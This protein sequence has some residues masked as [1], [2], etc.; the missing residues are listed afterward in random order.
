MDREL[1]SFQ[2]AAPTFD[3]G[4]ILK[5]PLL[6]RASCLV[7][8]NRLMPPIVD[9]PP[10]APPKPPLH[11]PPLPF[12]PAVVPEEETESFPFR[13]DAEEGDGEAAPATL[14]LDFFASRTSS[15]SNLNLWSP[16]KTSSWCNETRWGGRHEEMFAGWGEYGKMS[17][18]WGA[19]E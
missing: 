16:G 7:T 8:G 10:D 13:P 2:A 6:R 9:M 15:A 4:A 19:Q 3:C 5:S 14:D 11:V 1:T 18:Y 12:P 17:S